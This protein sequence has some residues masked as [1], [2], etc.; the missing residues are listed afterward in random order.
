MSSPPGTKFPR[1]RVTCAQ[2][3]QPQEHRREVGSS[4]EPRG[5]KGA[6]A[7]AGGSRGP[8]AGPL[9]P[10]AS[11][12]RPEDVSAAP[13]HPRPQ[14]RDGAA[15]NPAAPAPATAPGLHGWPATHARDKPR[16]SETE[17]G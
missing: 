2:R 11:P 16:L 8:R 1:A 13:P 12:H 17:R 7:G 4:S 15:G 5:L 6:E 14:P 10:A 3:A 9:P